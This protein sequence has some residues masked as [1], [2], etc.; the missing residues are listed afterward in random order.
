MFPF[1]LQKRISFSFFSRANIRKKINEVNNR[2]IVKGMSVTIK[3]VLSPDI[4]E[5]VSM[6]IYLKA[7]VQNYKASETASKVMKDHNSVVSFH[8][9][10][11]WRHLWYP[12]YSVGVR[13]WEDSTGDVIKVLHNKLMAII[14]SRTENASTE[15]HERPLYEEQATVL[16][17][18]E[19]GYWQKIVATAAGSA[20][21][22]MRGIIDHQ[23]P[24]TSKQYKVESLPDTSQPSKG[25]VDE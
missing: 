21:M 2:V 5:A 1:P 11:I 4:V 9:S 23:K 15:S 25:F 17:H 22:F 19:G 14:Q 16:I 3:E 6:E 18:P 12:S 13:L 8:T 7:F 10:S 20:L 24:C